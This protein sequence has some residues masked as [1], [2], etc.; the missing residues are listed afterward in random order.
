MSTSKTVSLITGIVGLL[1]V[2][3]VTLPAS[4]RIWQRLS[5]RK[6][7]YYE[8]LPDLYEDEDGTATKE[9]AAAFS[10]KFHKVSVVV[11]SI[12]GGLLALALAVFASLAPGKSLSIEKWLQ[13]ASWVR[14]LSQYLS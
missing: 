8:E 9:A 5:P 2:A 1:I 10:D 13:F 7:S 6:Q 12:L 14:R 11:L 3:L 4:W